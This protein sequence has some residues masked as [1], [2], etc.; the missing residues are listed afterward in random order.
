MGKMR[1]WKL[2][3]KQQIALLF[4][5][6]VLGGTVYGNLAGQELS[7]GGF[8]FSS[9]LHAGS[10]TVLQSVLGQRIAETLLL[11][12][13]SMTELAIPVM[14][15]FAA[16]YG[17]LSGVLLT[18]C[19]IQK[20]M[21]GILFFWAMSLPQYL[22]YVPVWY[23]MA[24]WGYQSDHHVHWHGVF[25]AVLLVAAA[26]AAEAYLSP[27]LLQLLIQFSGG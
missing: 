15:L 2:G 9:L 19:V 24:L 17:F 10:K 12:V 7:F 6:G 16:L 23:Q 21:A 22:V 1:K 14:L 13:V 20:G 5:A 8:S 3:A 4:L 26:C 27:W 25:F 11:W 18:V